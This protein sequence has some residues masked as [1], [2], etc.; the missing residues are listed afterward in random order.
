MIGIKAVS[1][2][3]LHLQVSVPATR[4]APEGLK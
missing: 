2:Y 1:M 4:P 3:I